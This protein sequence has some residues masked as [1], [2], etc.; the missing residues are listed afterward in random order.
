MDK[1]VATVLLGRDLPLYQLIW[2][3]LAKEEHYKRLQQNSD[4]QV[5]VVET[6]VQKK[7]R[8]E[9]EEQQKQEEQWDGGIVTLLAETLSASAPKLN[10]T[11]L[12]SQ[13]EESSVEDIGEDG[14]EIQEGN[15]IETPTSRIS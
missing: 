2:G 14:V 6:R 15:S 4:K 8:L 7:Q 10:T 9:L 11:E 1:L 13:Q 3:K 5:L 12:D